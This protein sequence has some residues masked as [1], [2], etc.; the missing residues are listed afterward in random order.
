M[1][2][3]LGKNTSYIL[4]LLLLVSVALNIFLYL[5]RSKWEEAWI[6]QTITTSDIE[7]LLGQSGIDL[8][9]EN[10][11]TIAEKRFKDDVEEIELEIDFIVGMEYDNKALLFNETT[12][13][14]VNGQYAG[15]KANL[16]FN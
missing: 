8:S 11:K 12:L 13:I 1:D 5:E 16:P 3:K 6:N 10:V 2:L 14:F 4:S 7:Q 9:Y 15:S